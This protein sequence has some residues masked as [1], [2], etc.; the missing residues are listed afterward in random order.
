LIVTDTRRAKSLI[1]M[2]TNPVITDRRERFMPRIGAPYIQA[3]LD[4]DVHVKALTL[5]QKTGETKT[6]FLTRL[7]ENEYKRT[8]TSSIESR[9]SETAVDIEKLLSELEKVSSD[10]TALRAGANRIISMLFV[11]IKENYRTLSLLTNFLSKSSLLGDDQLNILGK[12]SDANAVD[13][14]KAAINL[15]A[16]A[17]IDDVLKILQKK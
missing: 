10:T 4:K 5:L 15:L 11:V 3:Q 8:E 2:G 17:D 16:K 6:A 13:S 14:F 9:V 7:I 1:Y 12:E